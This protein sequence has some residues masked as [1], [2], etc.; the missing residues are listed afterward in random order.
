MFEKAKFNISE[1]KPEEAAKH[2]TAPAF[3]LHAEEDYFV[4]EE[5][6]DR[7]FEAYAG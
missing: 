4:V 7:N 2:C 1:L 5:H 3:F 6:T